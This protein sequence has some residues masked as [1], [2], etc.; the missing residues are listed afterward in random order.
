MVGMGDVVAVSYT[1]QGKTYQAV[2][3]INQHGTVDYLTPQG[4]SFKKAFSRYLLNLATSAQ[5]SPYPDIILYC[6]IRERIKVLIWQRLL[7]PY[8]RYW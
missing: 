8:S 4:R 1:N 6:I 5:P 3:H 7:V 2:R